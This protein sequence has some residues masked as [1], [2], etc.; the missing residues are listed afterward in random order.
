MNTYKKFFIKTLILML[1]VPILITIT[2]LFLGD[3]FIGK[4]IVRYG[5]SQMIHQWMVQKRQAAEKLSN[6]GPKIVFVSGSNTLFGVSA[7]KIEKETGIPTLNYASHAGL[8][9]YIFYS[10]KKVLKKGDI[11]FLPLEYCF[12]FDKAEIN[13]LPTTLVEYTIAYD[14]EYYRQ[15]PVRSKLKVLAYLVRLDS[16]TALG[17]TIN[18]KYTLSN[19]GDIIDA[20]GT[21]KDYAKNAQFGEV[22]VEKLS[23]NYKKWELYK[24]LEWCKLKDIKVY[25]FAPN[26]YHQRIMTKDE[27]KAA[28][29]VRKFYDLVGVEF[30]GT[31]EDGFFNLKDICNTFYHL[32]QQGQSKRSNYFIKKIKELSLIKKF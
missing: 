32:N 26:L 4:G 5:E 27:Q 28:E 25:A 22:K 11:V 2:A 15:L 24:F 1:I 8:S 23:K 13:E 6:R 20:I 9:S 31:F 12:Y 16:L 3:Y 14:N 29:E 21:D 7:E 17:K 30:I 10:A 18:R 19:R